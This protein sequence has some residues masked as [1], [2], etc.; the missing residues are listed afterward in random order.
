MIGKSSRAHAT[1]ASALVAALA[2]SSCG[3]RGDTSTEV[4]KDKAGV[5]TGVGV[6]ADTITLGVLTDKSGPF[7][8]L[9]VGVAQGNQLWAEEIN[10]AGG[11]CGRKIVL[12]QADHNYK[13]DAAKTIYAQMQPKVAGFVQLL[14]SPILAAL[15]G[16]LRA[17]K[18]TAIALSWSSELL[19][20]PYVVV[21]GTTYDVEMINGL[22]YLQQEGRLADGD[23][24]GHI[25]IDGEYGKNGLRGTQYYAKQHNMN[26]KEVKVTATDADMTNIV[27][28]MKGAGVKAIMISTSPTQTASVLSANKALGLNVPVLGNNPTFNPTIL[29]SPAANAVEGYFVVAS[30]VPYS[31]D[32][33]KAQAVAKKYEAAGFSEPPFAGVTYGYANGDIFGQI[34]QKA[35]DNK[36]LSRAGIQRALQESKSIQ[37]GDLVAELDFSR[38]GAPPTRRVY[39]AR[40]DASTKGGLTY[41]KPLF[42]SEDAKS[43]KAPHEK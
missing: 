20:N 4:G 5:V 42:E 3:T 22:S 24:I 43:Y 7:K 33:P 17:D 16:N 12:E 32:I 36:D 1:A 39:V 21:A 26:L 38:A 8:A 27:T 37:T 31:A 25:Y 9:G 11:V 10:A 19:N 40:V 28:G 6:T 13:A 30:S 29:Q 2:L 41:V 14:G 34:L 18:A 35:C 23:T 15:E